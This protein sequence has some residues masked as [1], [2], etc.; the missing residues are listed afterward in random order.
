MQPLEYQPQWARIA[1]FHKFKHVCRLHLN[2]VPF[3][4]ESL[5]A[6]IFVDRGLAGAHNQ[7]PIGIASAIGRPEGGLAMSGLRVHNADVPADG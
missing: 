7:F 3:V 2:L 4:S 5:T 6:G 1:A